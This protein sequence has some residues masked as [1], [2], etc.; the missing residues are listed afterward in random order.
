MKGLFPT[1]CRLAGYVLL[2]AA[3]FLPLLLFLF[4]LVDYSHF[5]TVKATMKAVIVLCLLVI[6]FTRFPGIDEEEQ[7]VLRTRAL[8]VGTVISSLLFFLL[9]IATVLVPSTATYVTSI[10]FLF[11]TINV[12]CIEFF[13]QKRRIENKMRRN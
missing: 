7:T 4:R 10:G 12:I 8:A 2:I 11:L 5:E 1:P 3:V 9:T 6:T 13:F